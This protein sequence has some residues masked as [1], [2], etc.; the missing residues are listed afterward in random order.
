MNTRAGVNGP[1]K[2]APA[3]SF[4]VP[5][6]ALQRK[7]DCGGT[8]GLTGQCKDCDEER[9]Q[10]SATTQAHQPSPSPQVAAQVQ[11]IRGAGKPLNP[12][13]RD[14]FEPRFGHDFSQVRVHTDARANETARAL[15]ARAYTLSSDVVFAEGEYKPDTTDGRRL[16]AHELTHV[17]QQQNSNAD[18]HVATSSF[19]ISS[20]ND[21][22]EVEA[23]QVASEVCSMDTAHEAVAHHAT[24]SAHTLHRQPAAAGAAVDP[25]PQDPPCGQVAQDVLKIVRKD[26]QDMIEKARETLGTLHGADLKQPDKDQ[27]NALKALSRNFRITPDDIEKHLGAIRDRLR[28]MKSRSENLG[29][30]D[31]VCPQSAKFGPCVGGD[32]YTR[33]SERG[34]AI[35]FCPS[36]FMQADFNQRNTFV[37]ELAHATAP[38]AKDLVYT[39]QRAYGVLTTADALINADSYAWVV[40]DLRE[41]PP[42]EER[43]V[44]FGYTKHPDQFKQCAG[45]VGTLT[46]ALA[47]AELA[48]AAAIRGLSEEELWR[49]RSER[50]TWFNV[51]RCEKGECKKNDVLAKRYVDLFLKADK[52]FESTGFVL[53]CDAS[54]DCKTGPAQFDGKVMHI[55]LTWDPA[56]SRFAY[57]GWPNAI[58]QAIY[59]FLEGGRSIGEVPGAPKE[60]RVGNAAA[61]A[62]HMIA[63]QRY[64]GSVETSADEETSTSEAA[65]AAA[66]AAP[67]RP[68][69]KASSASA[70]ASR[71]RARVAVG[72]VGCPVPELQ[73]KLQV[74]VKPDL[75]VNGVFNAETEKALIKFQEREKLIKPAKSEQAE[76]EGTFAE[77]GVADALTWTRLFIQLPGHH[78]MPTGEVFK[79]VGFRKED[80]VTMLD[81]DQQLLP[82]D[83]NF[84][85]CEVSEA[86]PGGG[87]N[88]C[89]SGVVCHRRITGGRW[90]VKENNTYGPDTVGLI[91]PQ[92]Q[93]YQDQQKVFGKPPCGFLIPQLMLVELPEGQ[94]EYVRNFQLYVINKKD[95]A[96]AKLNERDRRGLS[97]TVPSRNESEKKK[98]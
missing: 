19:S 6:A 67:I 13:L 43:F 85:G 25:G 54:K 61:I 50:L 66:P 71:K 89:C 52:L 2:S 31:L 36:F 69:K 35:G 98:K 64:E 90:T 68:D 26:A 65:S 46:K 4:T 60:F 21:P 96:C 3:R 47:E 76:T 39:S 7:C 15:N 56:V 80:E 77:K 87:V 9:L 42:D 59:A 84:K 86:D 14:F 40:T 8:A 55:C 81:F 44:Q 49:R 53:Q 79:V 73:E 16:L 94:F 10:R 41:V 11:S 75:V 5:S 95:L 32:A 28:D 29:E 83:I 38:G 62:S 20:V 23:D 12:E 37:H 45:F 17:V 58:L 57:F 22:S 93:T 27:R 34:K 18:A 74:L 51:V 88:T 91:L 30:S 97:M 82:A 92:V 70:A 48:N 63:M 33:K 78:G 1:G 72:A 24:S